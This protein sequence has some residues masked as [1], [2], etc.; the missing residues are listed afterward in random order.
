MLFKKNNINKFKV[1]I[2]RELKDKENL[3]GFLKYLENYIF[4]LNPNI[5][6]YSD[7]LELY[8]TNKNENSKFLDKLYLTNNICEAINSSINYYLPKRSSNNSDSL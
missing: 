5:Y 6:N 8:F 4:K 1:I 7:I 2:K 3:K